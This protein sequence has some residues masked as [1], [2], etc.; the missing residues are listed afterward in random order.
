MNSQ[1]ISPHT[2]HHEARVNNVV[3]LGVSSRSNVGRARERPLSPPVEASS[4][5]GCS[6]P[7]R[8]VGQFMKPAPAGAGG[9]PEPGV[10]VATP[11]RPLTHTLPRRRLS[12]KPPKPLRFWA[13]YRSLKCGDC[14]AVLGSLGVA[15]WHVHTKHP[16]RA[17]VVKCRSCGVEW[18]SVR[19]YS[20]H[21]RNCGGSLGRLSAARALARWLCATGSPFSTPICRQVGRAGLRAGPAVSRSRWTSNKLEVLRRMVEQSGSSPQ[22]LRT[23]LARF[24]GKTERQIRGRIRATR[25][26]LGSCGNVATGGSDPAIRALSNPAVE[27][28]LVQKVGRKLRWKASLIAKEPA[29][30]VNYIAKALFQVRMHRH[31]AQEALE[32]TTARVVKEIQGLKRTAVKR[33]HTGKPRVIPGP[34]PERRRA[35]CLGRREKIRRLISEDP[36]KLAGLLLD[37]VEDVDCPI[38]LEDLARVLGDRWADCGGYTGLGQFKAAGGADNGCFASLFEPSEVLDQL[39][40]V[41]K[42]SAAGPD[43]ISVKDLK[44]WDPEGVKLCSLFNGW[45]VSGYIP[46]CVKPARTVLLPKTTEVQ[47]LNGPGNWRPITI[48][49]F[50]LRLFSK[51]LHSRLRAACPISERQRGFVSAPV[52]SENLFSLM[53]LV[54][55]AHQERRTLAVVFLDVAKAFDTVCHQHIFNALRERGVDSHVVQCI[56]SG[57]ESCT[58]RIAL[59][60]EFSEPIATTRGVRQGD[61]LSPLLFN[62]A[63]DPLLCTLSTEG[64]GVSVGGS[65]VA[66]LAFADDLV[67][68]SD[69]WGGMSHNLEITAAFCKLTGIR[70][71]PEKSHGFLLSPDPANKRNSMRV[72]RCRRWTVA[73][74]SIPLVCETDE[75]VPRDA[76]MSE[77]GSEKT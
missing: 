21:K 5:G 13:P 68:L 61:P 11:T 2:G 62:L 66:A 44:E 42:G 75:T 10:S 53:T 57:Y 40:S 46:E 19:E 58:T 16:G 60:G 22:V 35:K 47:T 7:P 30:G 15:R 51:L 56:R 24:P 18:F 49:S 74:E 9:C 32:R 41:K 55:K 59:R 34:H 77:K 17:F 6:T 39:L 48:G 38:P 27:Y 1:T 20:A 14:Q 50:L 70:I 29:A 28:P 3:R 31:L 37:G 8:R 23:A 69:S 36:G 43:G 76:D 25:I 73:G 26:Q 65:N 33:T 4:G 45:W 52:C 71:Q 12:G 72:N 54:R 63:M 67:L 64:R